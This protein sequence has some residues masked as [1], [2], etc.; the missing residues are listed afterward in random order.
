MKIQTKD[1]IK[2]QIFTEKLLSIF[3]NAGI[4]LERIWKIQQNALTD[5]ENA[6]C[7]IDYSFV[8]QEYII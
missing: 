7:C 4:F 3:Y 5:R 8:L 6:F 1:Q 2:R